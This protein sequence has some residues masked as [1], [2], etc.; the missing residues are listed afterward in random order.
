MMSHYKGKKN[1]QL[2]KI[3]RST[4]L[5][6]FYN[7][8]NQGQVISGGGASWW[9]QHTLYLF[10]PRYSSTLKAEGLL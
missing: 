8:T 9:M 5:D 10:F 6:M 1:L 2:W 7:G 3:C 4:L